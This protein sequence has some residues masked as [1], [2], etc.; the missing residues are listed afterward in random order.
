M[1]YRDVYHIFI[2][3]DFERVVEFDL[4]TICTKLKSQKK[5]TTYLVALMEQLEYK[6]MRD[7]FLL[8]LKTVENINFFFPTPANN[9]ICHL[10][11]LERDSQK[12]RRYREIMNA[13][14]DRKEI[15]IPTVINSLAHCFETNYHMEKIMDI[16][17][18]LHATNPSMF[19]RLFI[20]YINA[21]KY[22]L[23]SR[24]MQGLIDRCDLHYY[25]M[26]N[27]LCMIQF[28]N[29]IPMVDWKNLHGYNRVKFVGKITDLFFTFKNYIMN[30]HGLLYIFR[31]I[32]Q[33]YKI[34][35]HVPH[36]LINK[37]LKD[38]S[39]GP[40]QII[41]INSIHP[42]FYHEFDVPTSVALNYIKTYTHRKL[43]LIL[44]HWR[45][46]TYCPESKFFLKLNKMYAEHKT[47]LP[48]L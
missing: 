12:R 40:A 33:T 19:S 10:Q 23:S 42:F 13:L 31:S 30:P 26:S 32:I 16:F 45:H 7:L 18:R 41:L 25:Q 27:L 1:T 35:L 15:Q 37:I 17:N 46:R 44:R 14:L 11:H 22:S 4:D 5:R 8:I 28:L 47:F 9:A 34:P 39:T 6:S 3:N 38:T 36:E 21:N 29:Y 20:N 2:T 24:I 43:G 48:K